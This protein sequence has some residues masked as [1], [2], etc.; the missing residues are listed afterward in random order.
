MRREEVDGFVDGLFDTQ[1]SLELTDRADRGLK[2]LSEIR[3][4]FAAAH[5]LLK[6][7]STQANPDEIHVTYRNLVKLT[8]VAEHEI[9]ETVLSCTRARREAIAGMAISKPMLN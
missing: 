7:V 1:D 6:D 9:H 5:S 2:E 4:T 3:A 8:T